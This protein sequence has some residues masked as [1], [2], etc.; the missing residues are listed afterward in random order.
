MA[1]VWKQRRG[2]SKCSDPPSSSKYFETPSQH[3][4]QK[5][6]LLINLVIFN[7]NDDMNEVVMNYTR[8]REIFIYVEQ[9]SVK[10]L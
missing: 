2:A 9:L 6:E 8:Q 4:T 7:E 5:I 1:L 3:H 10:E